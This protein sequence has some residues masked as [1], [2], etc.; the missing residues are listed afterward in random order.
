MSIVLKP[1][2]TEKSNDEA[3][4]RGRYGFYVDTSANKIQI[5][6]EIEKLY[7]VSV[8]KVRTMNYKGKLKTRYTK[9]G[10]QSGRKNHTKKAFVE[11][12]DGETID[13]Y[14]DI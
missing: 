1:I 6:K 10:L 9:T 4:L 5:K 14:G 7:S 13:H 8:V 3:E 11:L 2:I 12:A